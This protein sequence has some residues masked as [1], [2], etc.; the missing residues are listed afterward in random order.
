MSAA[1]DLAALLFLQDIDSRLDRERHRRAHLP[2]R[3]E[4]ADLER[5]EAEAV[6]SRAELAVG[7]AEVVSR[8][9]AA[10]RELKATEDRA[11]QVSGRLYGG[12]V[13]ASRELQAMAGEV[14]SLRKRASELEDRALELME[15]REPL[16]AAVAQV[17]K[18]LAGLSERKSEVSARLARADAEAASGIAQLAEERRAAEEAVV[19]A[20]RATYDRLRAKLDGVAVSR[21]VGGRCD[22]CHLTLPAVELDRIRHE[23]PG[24]LEYCDQC[25]RILVFTAG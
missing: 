19:P 14:E 5:Q 7:L 12:S 22:G 1:P 23:P 11:A 15:E 13:T 21:L 24:K 2:E 20:L 16:D 25:G 9:S 4:L 6:A 10:E 18:V 3:T 8:E 17:D